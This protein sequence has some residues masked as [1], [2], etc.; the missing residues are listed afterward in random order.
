M[1]PIGE[2]PFVENGHDDRVRRPIILNLERERGVNFAGQGH[3]K[4]V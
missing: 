2:L 1:V 4:G 3:L